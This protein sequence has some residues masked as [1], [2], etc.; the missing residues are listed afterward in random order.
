LDVKWDNTRSGSERDT[1]ANLTLTSFSFQALKETV[2]LVPFPCWG[3]AVRDYLTYTCA[4]PMESF[5]HA[6]TLLTAVAYILS[7]WPNRIKNVKLIILTKIK[8]VFSSKIVLMSRI[9]RVRILSK[10]QQLTVKQSYRPIY[11]QYIYHFKKD[12]TPCLVSSQSACSVKATSCFQLKIKFANL[13]LFPTWKLILIL[14]GVF[15]DGTRR[16]AVPEP[17]FPGI[18]IT[19]SFSHRVLCH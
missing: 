3:L 19:P 8:Q 13:L 16:N 9:C 4:R 12:K 14:P 1:Y 6:S 11:C 17:L 5:G 10:L 18:G 7:D 2:I 15:C